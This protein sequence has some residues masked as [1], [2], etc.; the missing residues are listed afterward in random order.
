MPWFDSHAGYHDGQQRDGSGQFAPAA[1]DYDRQ[2]WSHTLRNPAHRAH[3]ISGAQQLPLPDSQ[4]LST[5]GSDVT[6]TRS[7]RDGEE[8]AGSLPQRP[9]RRLEGGDIDTA[10]QYRPLPDPIP[11]RAAETRGQRGAAPARRRSRRRLAYGTG[12]RPARQHTQSSA[13]DDDY[14]SGTGV[15][16]SGPSGGASET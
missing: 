8:Q 6:G 7:R 11:T 10:A 3:L 9:A 1:P 13:G 16:T 5:Q 12:R 2:L 14:G 15:D 4:Q